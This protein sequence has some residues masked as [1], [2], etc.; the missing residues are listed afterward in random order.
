MESD[1]ELG[2]S[3][4]A[5]SSAFYA[6]YHAVL[7]LLYKCGIK[8]ENHMGTIILLKEIFKIDNTEMF[9]Y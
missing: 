5:I 7:A 4:W 9:I 2:Y 1:I 8:S 3:D 6:M